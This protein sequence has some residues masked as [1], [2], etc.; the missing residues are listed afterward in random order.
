MKFHKQNFNPIQRLSIL[1][2]AWI[3]PI[4]FWCAKSSHPQA[5]HVHCRPW[6]NDQLAIIALCNGAILMSYEKRWRFFHWKKFRQ[7]YPRKDKVLI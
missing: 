1:H 5:F 7:K 4:P 6:I 3:R 2:A